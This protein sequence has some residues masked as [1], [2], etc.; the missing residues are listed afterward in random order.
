MDSE[1]LLPSEGLNGK[2]NNVVKGMGERKIG[3]GVI[4]YY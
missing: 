3:V 2:S 4:V 1:Y